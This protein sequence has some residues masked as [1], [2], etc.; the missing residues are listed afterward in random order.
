MKKKGAVYSVVA[1]MLCAAVYL[2]WSYHRDPEEAEKTGAT[3]HSKILGEAQLVD[4]QT[5][6]EK[7]G[8]TTASD[9][10]S[11]A[12]LSRQKARDEAVSIFKQT[13]ENVNADAKSKD[14]ATKS[15]AQM[16]ENAVKEARIEN[17]IVAKGYQECVA[18][19]ND[20]GINVIVQKT[21]EG[22]QSADIA[23]IK[24]IVMDETTFAAEAI[25]IIETE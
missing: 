17:L 12:R 3:D 1:L 22:L 21:K 14:Q 16:A 13:S 5:K 9:Y 23:K 18:F 10:F 4:A 25:K 2:N 8:E 20:D 24:D 6:G 11:Q 15:I 19:M 7:A